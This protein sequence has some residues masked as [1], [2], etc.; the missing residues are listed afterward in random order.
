MKFSFRCISCSL[1]VLLTGLSFVTPQAVAAQGQQV[2]PSE[3]RAAVRQSATVR[4]ENLNQVRSFFA[5]PTVTKILKDAHLDS[6]R[7]EKAMSTLNASELSKLAARTAQVQSDFAAGALTN[8]QLTY[9]VIAVG[10]A[11][12]V[13]VLV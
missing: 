2:T 5:D 9:I 4:Q 1:V 13:L 12:L 7:I 3:L 8:Q 10:A 6:G 11:V